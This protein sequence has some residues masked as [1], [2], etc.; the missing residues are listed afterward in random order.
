MIDKQIS[1][2]YLLSTLIQPIIPTVL[3]VIDG[4][5]LGNGCNVKLNNYKYL[6]VPIC[7]AKARV[8]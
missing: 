8:N 4:K 6:I 1:P 7:L 5:L 2:Y 3:G